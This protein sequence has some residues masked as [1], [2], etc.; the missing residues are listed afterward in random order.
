MQYFDLSQI[1]CWFC[2]VYYFCLKIL[3]CG[4]VISVMLKIDK[5]HLVITFSASLFS[6][7]LLIEAFSVPHH[8]PRV[9]VLILY[10]PKLVQ[11]RMLPSRVTFET[12]FDALKPLSFLASLQ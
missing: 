1:D 5:I 6:L 3:L 11:L 12:F 4:F 2:V 10:N 7:P 8:L 9:V